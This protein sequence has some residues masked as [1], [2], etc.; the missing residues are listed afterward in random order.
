MAEAATEFRAA[1]RLSPDAVEPRF[2][3]AAV[4]SA[5]EDW[6]EAADQFT[7]VLRREPTH[8]GSQRGLGIARKHRQKQR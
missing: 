4:L 8:A 3:L 2:Q 6:E 5:L 7:E 1:L